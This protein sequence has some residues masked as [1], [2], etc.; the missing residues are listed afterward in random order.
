MRIVPGVA[1]AALAFALPVA[2]QSGE[3]PCAVLKTAALPPCDAAAAKP[4]AP[5]L[6][7]L[8]GAPLGVSDLD[9]GLQKRV[10]TV[11]AVA[12]ARRG[13]LEAEIADVRL[14][15]EAG[16]RGVPFRDFW[17]A[18]VLRKTPPVTEAEIKEQFEQAKSGFA[19][20]TLED[21]RPM[22]A[23]SLLAEHRLRREAEVAAS[24]ETRFRRRPG[25]AGTWP[26]SPGR[27][28]RDGGAVVVTVFRPRSGSTPPHTARRDRTTT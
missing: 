5:V 17:E 1:L 22:L 15:L 16:R 24:L 21:L 28:P 4:A 25:P 6:A 9:E 27:P 20:K 18:E 8:D 12:A 7:T 2:A 11:D 19:G 3:A 26:A 14:H 13:A 10:A 23:S